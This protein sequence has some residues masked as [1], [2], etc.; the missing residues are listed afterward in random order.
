MH[1]IP[2]CFPRTRTRAHT[3]LRTPVSS[4]SSYV[5]HVKAV[6]CRSNRMYCGHFES[7]LSHATLTY[8]YHRKDV[9]SA[10][11]VE[12]TELRDGIPS[13]NTTQFRDVPHVLLHAPIQCARF[14]QALEPWLAHHVLCNGTCCGART[15]RWHV[16]NAV[17]DTGVYG[18]T[19]S[20]CYRNTVIIAV[21]HSRTRVVC[22][23]RMG[24]CVQRR[25][26]SLEN[27]ATHQRP[28]GLT[29]TL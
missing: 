9:R 24:S 21:L 8:H 14:T 23:A 2:S 6:A 29:T 1:E 25:S 16:P 15:A 12:C 5:N 3:Y 11:S 20:S 10:T 28:C 13:E 18:T 27:R 19:C 22:G 17:H 4:K 26:L 7:A